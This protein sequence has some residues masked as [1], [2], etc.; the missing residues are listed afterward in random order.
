MAR[1]KAARVSV[2][3]MRMSRSQAS[4][5]RRRQSADLAPRQ[6]DFA[7]RSRRL[8][9]LVEG[10]ED[11]GGALAELRRGRWGRRRI[12]RRMSC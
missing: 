8:P 6:A 7:R 4:A 10:Q 11:D 9:W 1:R 12:V 5:Q 3:S 2:H